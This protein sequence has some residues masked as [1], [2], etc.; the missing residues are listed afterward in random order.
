MIVVIF[1][2][3][4]YDVLFRNIWSYTLFFMPFVSVQVRL[5]WLF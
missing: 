5:T 1:L 3:F 4:K 2:Y